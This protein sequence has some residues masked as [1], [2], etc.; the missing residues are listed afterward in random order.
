MRIGIPK[1]VKV[2]EGRVAMI[3]P[4]VGELVRHG[5]E[6][7]IQSNA[8]VASGY[9]DEAFHRVGAQIVP[10][11]AALYGSVQMVVKVKEPIAS[12]Y[13]F[14]RKDHILFSFLHLAST[15][16]LAQALKEKGL[17]GI[18]FETVEAHGKLPLL[19]PMSDIAGRLAVHIGT[20]LLHG[21]A[22]GRGVMLGGLPSTERG[23]VV[24]LGAGV[25]GG[26]AVAV[27]AALGAQVTVLAPR[28]EELE[29]MHALGPNVTALPSYAPLILKAVLSA[30]LLIGAVLIPGAKAPKLVTAEMVRQMKPG[31]VIIDISVD[32][33]GCI[34]TIRPTD[35]D[36]PTYVQ[37][38]VVHFG[39]TNM[40]GAV[41]RTASQALS[42][43]LTPYVLKLASDGGLKDPAIAKG[44]NVAGGKIVHSAVAAALSP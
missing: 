13:A 24:I 22:G 36:H 27:A 19:A 32:Q 6:V 34:E 5:H 33:G 21:H 38:G 12:E 29:R 8:G 41:P 39:V 11:A 7:L 42:T 9:P 15:P 2:R 26:N 1:E 20:T 40:P 4:A 18:A 3:P 10:D 14:L 28:R 43:V 23:H 35:Y 37:D 25:A 17:T 31:S 44:L 30:D 16:K